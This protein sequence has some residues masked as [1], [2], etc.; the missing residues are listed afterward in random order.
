MKAKRGNKTRATAVDSGTYKY[1]GHQIK[2]GPTQIN[3][4]PH[5]K[6]LLNSVTIIQYMYDFQQKFIKQDKR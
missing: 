6:G 3:V 1:S 4:N 5:T 2:P